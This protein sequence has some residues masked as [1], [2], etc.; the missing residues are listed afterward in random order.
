MAKSDYTLTRE[1]RRSLA[2]H[3]AIA[4]KLRLNP[5]PVV[6]KGRANLAKLRLLH[7]N[8]AALLDRALARW[9]EWLT[10]PPAT[11]AERITG[12]DEKHA[13]MRHVSVFAGALSP[14]E[15]N[16]IIRSEF[17]ERA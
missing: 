15:R 2:F 16:R 11:L 1:D 8:R 14:N 4:E 9:E 6:A 3:M 12:E 5:D 13:Y 17:R 7:P 10:L